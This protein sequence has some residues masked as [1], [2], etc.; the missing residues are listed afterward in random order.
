MP[1]LFLIH[2]VRGHEAGETE[3]LIKGWEGSGWTVYWPIRD[4]EQSDPVGLDICKENRAGVE[5]ADLV[6]ILWDG[7]SSG[8]LFDAGMAFALRKPLLIVEVPPAT[9]GKSWENMFR[10][11]ERDGSSESSRDEPA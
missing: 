6:A 2:P 10:A 3:D 4:T 8:S 5:A 11:W 9:E 1:K 7:R